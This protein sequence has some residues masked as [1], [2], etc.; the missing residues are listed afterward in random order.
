MAI[1]LVMIMMGVF[2]IWAIVRL[3]YV[4][5]RIMAEGVQCNATVTGM[6]NVTSFRGNPRFILMV[7]F[8]C[9]DEDLGK[10]QAFTKQ[11]GSTK[12]MS[13]TRADEQKGNKIN[14]LY[15]KKHP[16]FVVSTN[17]Q[18]NIIHLFTISAITYL[19]ALYR[20]YLVYFFF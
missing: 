19:A 15:S 4:Y 13:I 2:I 16:D 17:W 9:Y 7:N 6:K 20:L 1:A 8:T 10:K 5:C 18:T 12:K 3:P 14:I 11:Y